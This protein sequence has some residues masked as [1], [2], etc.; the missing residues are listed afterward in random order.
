MF[1]YSVNSLFG[2]RL[3]EINHFNDMRMVDLGEHKVFI[4]S[5]GKEF[6]I[7]RMSNFDSI[8]LNSF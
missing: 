7:R 3:E 1:H 2:S 5:N 6:L 4:D 8:P